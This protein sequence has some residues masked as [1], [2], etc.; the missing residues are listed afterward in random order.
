MPDYVIGYSSWVGVGL[1]D[2]PPSQSLQPTTSLLYTRALGYVIGCHTH[3]AKSRKYHT[4]RTRIASLW[5]RPKPPALSTRLR[6]IVIALTKTLLKSLHEPTSAILISEV[7]PLVGFVPVS[8]S[9]NKLLDNVR[10]LW[11]PT[12]GKV[13][14]FCFSCLSRKRGRSCALAAFFCW[15]RWWR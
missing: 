11:A 8:T 3:I 6:H 15:M 5:S 13:P 9:R 12:P 4:V 14:L 2:P 1:R 10:C 7:A